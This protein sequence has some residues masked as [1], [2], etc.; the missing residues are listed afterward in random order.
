MYL[1]C[2]SSKICKYCYLGRKVKKITK[3]FTCWGCKTEHK[4]PNKFFCNFYFAQL[5]KKMLEGTFLRWSFP[6]FHVLKCFATTISQWKLE[7]GK[8]ELKAP[9]APGPQDIPH[10][11]VALLEPA[12]ALFRFIVYRPR[13]A[14][15][16]GIKCHYFFFLFFWQTDEASP[17]R[18]CYQRGL[19][20]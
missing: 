11:R 3:S 14:G 19:P 13:V 7:L 6:C 9:V 2:L 20:V 12:G 1:S 10:R 8:L 15:V 4:Y 16:S 17:G 5:G 18:V